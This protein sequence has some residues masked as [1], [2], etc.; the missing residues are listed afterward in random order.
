MPEGPTVA[1]VVLP[2]LQLPDGVGS[3]RF[4]DEKGHTFATPAIADGT[5]FTVIVIVFE[6]TAP[7]TIQAAELVIV[8]VI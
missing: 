1:I 3:L 6:F 8:Q 5:G 4:I 7:G 2:V